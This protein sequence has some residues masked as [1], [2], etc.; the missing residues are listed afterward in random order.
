MTGIG[1][2]EAALHMVKCAEENGNIGTNPRDRA[3]K[4]TEEEENMPSTQEIEQALMLMDAWGSGDTLVDAP[5]DGRYAYAITD[6]AP[7]FVNDQ[8]PESRRDHYG[9]VVTV[10][11]VGTPE[12]EDYHVVY[13]YQAGERECPGKDDETHPSDCALCGG[14]DYVYWGDEWMVYVLVPDKEDDETEDM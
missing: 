13:S 8:L 1:T 12:V 7:D 3:P 9:G 5:F 6:Y 10:L 4:K 11:C 2:V 14:D